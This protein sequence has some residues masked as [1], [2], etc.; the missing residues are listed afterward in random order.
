MLLSLPPSSVPLPLPHSSILQFQRSPLHHAAWEGYD[1]VCRLLIE[2]KADVHARDMV[3][4]ARAKVEDF[5]RVQGGD[6]GCVV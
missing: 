3:M 5:G 2:H 1:T 6:V 4:D